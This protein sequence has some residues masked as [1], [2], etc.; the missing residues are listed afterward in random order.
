MSATSKAIPQRPQLE[1]FP[2]VIARTGRS[3]SSILRDVAAGTFPK[4][5]RI[6]ARAIAWEAAAVDRWIAERLAGGAAE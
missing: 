4:P 6:G 5:V 3:K 2:S 1:R